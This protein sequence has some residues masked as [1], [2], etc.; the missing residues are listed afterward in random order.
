MTGFF[1]RS[2]QKLDESQRWP[3]KAAVNSFFEKQVY[4]PQLGTLTVLGSI[5]QEWRGAVGTSGGTGFIKSYGY[6]TRLRNTAPPKFLQPV[7]TAFSVSQQ[8]EVSA[9]YDATGAPTS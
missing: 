9:A 3:L 4:G 2:S 5:A 8:V 6:D 1:A 7:T